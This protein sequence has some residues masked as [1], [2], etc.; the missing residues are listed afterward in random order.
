MNSKNYALFKDIY[1]VGDE[2]G[3]KTIKSSM[4]QIDEPLM[5]E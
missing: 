5:K 4:W 3:P 1:V 2:E